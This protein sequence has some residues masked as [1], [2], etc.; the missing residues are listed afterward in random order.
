MSEMPN[1]NTSLA[2]VNVSPLASL[3]SNPP[4]TADAPIASSAMVLKVG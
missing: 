2:A 4:T 1:A 3:T